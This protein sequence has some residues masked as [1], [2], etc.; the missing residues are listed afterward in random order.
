M[1]PAFA[2]RPASSALASAAAFD[3]ARVVQRLGAATASTQAT[4]VSRACCSI[5]RAT[6][7]LDLLEALRLQARSQRRGQELHQVDGEACARWRR[8]RRRQVLEVEH[9]IRQPAGL[10][11]VGLG[12]ADLPVARLQAGICQR[13]PQFFIDHGEQRARVVFIAR[14]TAGDTGTHAGT[15][16]ADAGGGAKAA[17]AG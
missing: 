3:L 8:R 1:L 12:D 9:R 13:L 6:S 2:M 7:Q 4:R 10:G 5:S 17:I 15:L 14:Q 16:F 11:Q